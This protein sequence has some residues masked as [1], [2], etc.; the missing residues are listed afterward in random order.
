[1]NHSSNTKKY[2]VVILLIILVSGVVTYK[3]YS[4]KTVSNI[5]TQSVNAEEVNKTPSVKKV[6]MIA[7]GDIMMH[8]SQLD[9]TYNKK[10]DSYDFSS[11][12]E[13]INKYLKDGDIVYANL[14]TPVAGKSLKYTGYPKF[15]APTEIL[16]ELK[17]NYFTHLSLANN[18]ALD[19]GAVGL[20]STIKN[21][22][23]AGLVGF[24]AREASST[25]YQITEK[26]GL[27]MGFLS[28]TYDT[29]GLTLPKSKGG[30]LSYINKEQI[31]RDIKDLKIQNVDVIT[32]ALHFG[33]EYKLQEN[34]SQRELAKLACDNGADIILGDHP[35]VLQ[36]IKFLEDLNGRK[37]LVIY[38]LG[39]FISGMTNPYTDLGGIL[40][41]E[42]TKTGVEGDN[43]NGSMISMNPNFVATWVKRGTNTD[44]SRYYTILP[45]DADKIP[46]GIKIT[47]SE[48]RRL[49]LYRNF[50]D[51]KIK[52]Y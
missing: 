39:N 36:P 2:I 33:I 15:N 13:N 3:Y 49:E 41:I 43:F 26:S 10:T 6:T 35:H 31:V 45:L 48:Q 25:N 37:C 18:H 21:V 30:M 38:S 47:S 51:T 32:V 5:S 23:E 4:Q 29:N 8:Q 28:Y 52:A 50:V 44:G 17:D 7:V 16:G 24:G 20:S 22:E 12:F 40:N 19:R 42:I 1:M 9:A 27:K 34:A 14:E 11:F 46:S